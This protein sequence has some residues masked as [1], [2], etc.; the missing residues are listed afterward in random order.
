[1]GFARLDVLTGDATTAADEADLRIA[2]SA[3]DVLRT[4]NGSDYVGK[5]IL[6]T[7]IRI[8]DRANGFFLNESGTVQDLAFGIPVDCVATPDPAI[9]SGCILNT[10]ADTLVPGFAREGKRAIV[11]TFS[12]QL[13]DAGPDADIGS[14][15]TCPPSCGTGDEQAF[16]R[17]GVFT[18]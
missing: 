16:L 5:T 6:T 1:M 12:M 7:T 13:N 3:T 15:A 11:S 2:A 9:G 14:P 17:Q 10:T 4:S 8:T 18:P